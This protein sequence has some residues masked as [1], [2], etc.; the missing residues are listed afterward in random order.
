M[1]AASRK[2]WLIRVHVHMSVIVPTR[3]ALSLLY[4]DGLDVPSG[5][6]SPQGTHY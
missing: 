5:K 3:E 6:D 1:Q 2:V 4:E